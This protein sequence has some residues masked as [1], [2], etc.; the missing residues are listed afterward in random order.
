LAA[1]VEDLG[2]FEA[3]ALAAMQGAATQTD[4]AWFRDLH[5]WKVEHGVV[6]YNKDHAL[7]KAILD[8]KLR[9]MYTIAQQIETKIR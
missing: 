6:A 8:E 9:R 7:L 4:I 1:F 5:L 3:D 2:T